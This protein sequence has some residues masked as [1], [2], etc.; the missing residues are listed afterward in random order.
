MPDELKSAYERA[1][2][3]LKEKGID[4]PVESLSEE[5]KG[6]I[7]QIRNLY[8]SKLAE[9]EIKK[10]GDSAKAQNVEELEKIQQRFVSA[11]ARA[12]EEMERKISEVR[13]RS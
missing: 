12:E 1:L 13:K 2:E 10:Q 8:K 5:K 4:D 11:R 9:L 3:K 7:A 6:E